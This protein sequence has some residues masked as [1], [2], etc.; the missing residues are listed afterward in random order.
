MS[1]F[2]KSSDA[3][4]LHKDGK[5]LHIY[6]REFIYRYLYLYLHLYL[7]LKSISIAIPITISIYL[8]IYLS[9]YLPTYLCNSSFNRSHT[10]ATATAKSPL[11]YVKKSIM[12]LTYIWFCLDTTAFASSLAVT[13]FASSLDCNASLLLCVVSQEWWY[14]ALNVLRNSQS[15]SVAWRQECVE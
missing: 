7:Y 5:R 4:L 3:I 11:I 1:Q 10:T 2:I 13:E 15:H 12:K 6:S 9:I 14:K 8:P